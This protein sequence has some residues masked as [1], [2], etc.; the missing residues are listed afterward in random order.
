M[1]RT[2]M[3]SSPTKIDK[4]ITVEKDM[5]ERVLSFQNNMNDKS[6]KFENLK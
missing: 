6:L 3:I 1:G 5:H 2:P 4:V